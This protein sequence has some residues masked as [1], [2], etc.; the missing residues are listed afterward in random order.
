MSD[1]VDVVRSALDDALLGGNVPRSSWEPVDLAPVLAADYSGPQPDILSRTDGRTLLYPSRVHW[2]HGEPESGKSW[3]ALAAVVEVLEAGLEVVM[4]DWEDD[5]PST[6]DRLRRIGAADASIR[7]R[8]RYIRPEEPLTLEALGRL[9]V[10]VLPGASL[11]VLDATTPAMALD[12]LDPI[13]TRDTATWLQ[14]IPAAGASAGAAVLVLDHVV[15]ANGE[16]GRWAI[17]SQAKLAVV[18][19]AAYSLVPRQPIAPGRVGH[20]TLS[21]AKDRPGQVRA[22]AVGR[23]AGELIVDARDPGHLEIRIDPPLA[24]AAT[25]EGLSPSAQLLLEVL[26]R[27]QLEAL[28]WRD[29]GDRLAERGHPLKRSTIMTAAAALVA[30]GLVQEVEVD[31]RGSKVWWVDG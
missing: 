14:K 8:L 21:I 9:R 18:T 19:G 22:V 30:E 28:G 2:L 31:N 11:V 25:P 12:G 10:D 13:S 17:G 20:S 24:I 26:P 4:F 6:V 29:L 23:S 7:E 3:L 16:R 15:K 5:A 1:P 27:G